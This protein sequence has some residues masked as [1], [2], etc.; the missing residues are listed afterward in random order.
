MAAKSPALFDPGDDFFQ[1]VVGLVHLAEET[2]SARRIAQF[3]QLDRTDA[4]KKYD[5]RRLQTIPCDRH[6]LVSLERR[7]VDIDKDQIG[8]VSRDERMKI[9]E[10]TGR[11]H[12]E[13]GVFEE[14]LERF[15]YTGVVIEKEN[16][17]FQANANCPSYGEAQ[18]KRCASR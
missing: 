16:C 17:A 8:V 3:L 6:D 10:G 9:E 14:C 11:V 18:S 5:R 12:L 2:I 15:Q 7:H 4:G 1:D 13:P